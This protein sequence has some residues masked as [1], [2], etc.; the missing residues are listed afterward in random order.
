MN[1]KRRHRSPSKEAR[2]PIRNTNKSIQ[3]GENKEK[4]ENKT[5]KN[6]RKIFDHLNLP[7]ENDHKFKNAKIQTSFSHRNPI[8][9]NSRED[10][11]IKIEIDEGG[12]KFP[13]I[14]EIKIKKS[15][16]LSKLNKGEKIHN[17]N[18]TGQNY[19][20]NQ[21][22]FSISRSKFRSRSQNTVM[23]G[24]SPIIIRG[25]ENLKDSSL[26][27]EENNR[28]YRVI[29]KNGDTVFMSKNEYFAY[30][31]ALS[32]NPSS[33][34]NRPYN[35]DNDDILE[36]DKNSLKDEVNIEEEFGIFR[37]EKLND[38]DD[39]DNGEISKEIIETREIFDKVFPKRKPFNDA[40]A[41]TTKRQGDII[42]DSLKQKR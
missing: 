40:S 25:R 39:E 33:K 6:L 41:K 12:K 28:Q 24:D 32:Q 8:K 5:K 37:E 23:D 27:V 3:T 1:Y 17:L 11:P 22:K 13:I 15:I 36:D 14:E 38:D 31:L 26:S 7:N 21:N 19:Y 20:T 16:N 9:P 2:N 35:Y 34:K 4:T 30:Q 10:S 42:F 29:L 18:S